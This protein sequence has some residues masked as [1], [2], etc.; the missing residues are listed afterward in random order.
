[1]IFS[2]RLLRYCTPGLHAL[3]LAANVALVARRRR[4]PLYVVTLALQLALLRGG[5]ARR[6]RCARG[7][8]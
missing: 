1:M 3:A 8:C 4:S 6:A 2:H 5:R 7:R